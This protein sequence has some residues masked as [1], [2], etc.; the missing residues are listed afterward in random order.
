MIDTTAEVEKTQHILHGQL[1]ERYGTYG[2]TERG[3]AE[4][5]SYLAGTTLRNSLNLAVMGFGVATIALGTGIFMLITGIALS[6]A[7]VGLYRLSGRVS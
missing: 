1:H 7:G 5:A 3:S 4:R 6:G 2:E